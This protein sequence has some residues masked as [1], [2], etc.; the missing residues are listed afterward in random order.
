MATESMGFPCELSS[1]FFFVSFLRHMYTQVYSYSDASI[2]ICD[3]IIF[4]RYSHFLGYNEV[5]F[6]G[7]LITYLFLFRRS[8]S[9]LTM[10]VPSTRVDQ[11]GTDDRRNLYVL[12]LPFALTKSVYFCP[13]PELS[14]IDSKRNEFASV[15]SQY[16]TVSHC[17]ILATVDNSSRRRGFVVMSTHDEARHAMACLT[18]TLIKY[19]VQVAF[20][21][22]IKS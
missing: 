12:G 19:T 22:D 20:R 8:V 14:Q 21:L 18:R 15:F 9:A 3:S 13:F 11:N 2:S 5:V 10:S 1:L 16:G 17:V 6:P 7:L 4:R